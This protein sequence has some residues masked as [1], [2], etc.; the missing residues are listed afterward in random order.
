MS[1]TSLDGID[2]AICRFP[3]THSFE[4][5][6]FKTISYSKI[7]KQKLETA[8]TLTG[9]EL[10][11]LE[12]EYSEY[13]AKCVLDFID[14]TAENVDF[15]ACHGHTIFHQPDNKLTLQIMD[16]SVLANLTGITSI[17]DFRSGDMA[18][19][20]QGAPLVPIGDALLFGEYEA[21]LNLGG[22]ANLSYEHNNERIAYDISPAN[23]I[24]NELAQRKSL[25]YDKGGAMAKSGKIIPDILEKL[26]SL[27]FYSA[28][29]PKSLGREWME[30]NISPVFKKE[31][32]H[33]S[34][35]T[36]IEHISNQIAKALNQVAKTGKVMVTGGGA[37]NTFLMERVNHKT[38]LDLI[39]PSSSI[40]D[41]KE[42]IVF[43]F[44]GKLRLEEKPNTLASVTGA[45][46]N[47]VGG[48][49]YLGN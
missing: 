29:F 9:L 26:D 24:L 22:F 14:K 36:C 3:N 30:E 5:K 35:A 25:E 33:D 13:T 20:G 47:S 39:I 21:C 42:A 37:H 19:G 15:I 46:R 49:V 38:H 34:L 32:T 4:L 44:L 11:K 40:I 7:W 41:A 12:L 27:P 6:H 8:H 1:G 2:L 45:K 28:P 43:A 48:A 31:D 10:R 16:G 17:C 23:L 18:L